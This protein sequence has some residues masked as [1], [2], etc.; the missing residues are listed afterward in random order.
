MTECLAGSGPAGLRL[1]DF[2]AETGQ[3]GDGVKK[4]LME[5]FLEFE[6]EDTR[7]QQ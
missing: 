5:K 3:K 1:H 2:H 7:M 6:G 4:H